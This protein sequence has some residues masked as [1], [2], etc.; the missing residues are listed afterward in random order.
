V[1]GNELHGVLFHPRWFYSQDLHSVTFKDREY[2]TLDGTLPWDSSSGCQTSYLPLPAGGWEIAPNS[3]DSRDVIAAYPWGTEC[4]L[5]SSGSPVGTALASSPGGS[6]GSSL[7]SSGA[8]YKPSSC[9]RR[10]LLS[11]ASTVSVSKAGEVS[12]AHTANRTADGRGW[13]PRA[14]DWVVVC[15][16]SR[17]GAP[18][19][20]DGVV[21][22]TT[23]DGVDGGLHMLVGGDAPWSVAEV[24]ALQALKANACGMP[25]L[26]A[27]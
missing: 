27:R 6:C 2:R 22:T 1:S 18:V 14:D 17:A 10:I 16:T 24:I 23:K 21:R 5:M 12:Y 3:Q 9:S 20:V 7:Y 4:V 8:T 19:L 15:G 11:R 26:A 25:V 13:P